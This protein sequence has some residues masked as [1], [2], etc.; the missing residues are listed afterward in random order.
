MTVL[1]LVPSH[2]LYSNNPQWW[3]PE[4]NPTT[5]TTSKAYPLSLR[6]TSPGTDHTTITAE[7]RYQHGDSRRES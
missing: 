1:V 4:H 7:H 6:P 2:S 5:T 3:R